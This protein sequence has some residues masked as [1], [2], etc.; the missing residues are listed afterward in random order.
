[1]RK[2]FAT[3]FT[4]FFMA[5]LL[6][7]SCSS[8]SK[9]STP[10]E[11]IP[12]VIVTEPIAE[13]QE[14]EGVNQ[15]TETPEIPTEEV[16]IIEETSTEANIIEHQDIPGEPT[17]SQSL[18]SDCNTGF[19]V[20]NGTFSIKAPCDNWAINLLERPVSADQSKFYHYLDI[21]NAKA[22]QSDEW[23]FFRI[24][25]FGAGFPDDGTDFTYYFELDTNQDGRGNYLL[26]VTDLDLYATEWSVTG[27]Q[28][29]KD[30]NGD[31]GSAIA[32]RPDNNAT[33]NGYDT[34]LFDQ[35]LGD[36]PDLAWVRHNPSHYNQ[37]EF[38]V[39]KS[40][41]G[42]QTN[43]MWWAGAMLGSFAPQSFDLVDSFTQ[44]TLY[45]IDTT[46][47]WVLGRETSYNIRKCYIAPE[48]TEGPTRSSQPVEEVCVQ[49]PNPNP[50]DGCW[51]W[52]E[53]DCE[54][55][56]FN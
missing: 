2:E 31:V 55:V 35:G 37:I 49:P 7:T 26:A 16:T 21:L 51:I 18:P 5:S 8:P 1:M 34:L 41:V 42:S 50:Q 56:C 23:L 46:C 32:I 33:G 44:D 52:I 9:T 17:Y 6:I 25:L 45:S 48:P 11:D 10:I 39:K 4:T 43:L 40:L 29:Y 3:L 12:T 19:N 47:G 38:A 14:P 22:G 13:P 24:D 54:W 28:V 15:E 53:E 30:Q 36:D 20:E 27:L